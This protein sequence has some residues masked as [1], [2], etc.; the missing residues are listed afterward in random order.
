MIGVLSTFQPG[1]GADG[2]PLNYYTN[3]DKGHTAECSLRIEY[4]D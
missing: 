2:T 3:F 4:Q 1:Q